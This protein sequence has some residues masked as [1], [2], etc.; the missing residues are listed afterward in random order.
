MGLGSRMFVV[1]EMTDGSIM[2]TECYATDLTIRRDPIYSQFDV[3][4]PGTP[5][6]TPRPFMERA[7]FNGVVISRRIF[8]P[9]ETPTFVPTPAGELEGPQVAIDSGTGI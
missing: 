9:G 5:F 8:K 4:D 7:T 2:V 3:P 6:Q 1:N